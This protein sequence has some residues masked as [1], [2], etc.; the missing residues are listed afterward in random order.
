MEMLLTH[1]FFWCV[2]QL[3]LLRIWV[4][5]K[6]VFL[7]RWLHKGYVRQS[8]MLLTYWYFLENLWASYRH[9]LCLP[10]RVFSWQNSFGVVGKSLSLALPLDLYEQPRS[11]HKNHTWRKKFS[12]S[13]RR[14]EPQS[15]VHVLIYQGCLSR[16]V[17]P[18][19]R[20][21]YP[22]PQLQNIFSL[23]LHTCH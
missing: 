3:I 21:R 12:E 20:L 10:L 18:F 2:V 1:N 11:L 16:H 13:Q 6:G 17:W 22:V 23:C 5:R 8:T 19:W 9:L 7:A 4:H 14:L 15:L